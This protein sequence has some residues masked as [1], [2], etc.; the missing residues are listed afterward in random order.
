MTIFIAS[1]LTNSKTEKVERFSEKLSR[2]IAI[3]PFE[4]I[5]TGDFRAN[6]SSDVKFKWI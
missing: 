2:P 4:L 1:A 5:I 6:G 3:A